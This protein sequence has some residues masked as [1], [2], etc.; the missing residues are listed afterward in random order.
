MSG[1]HRLSCPGIVLRVGL[2]I[3]SSVATGCA[4][5]TSEPAGISVTTERP[6]G[7]GIVIGVV[8][9]QWLLKESKLGRQ[10]NDTLNQFMKD[11]QTL[12]ELEQQELRNLENELLRQGSVLSPSAKQQKEEQLRQRMLDYQQKAGNMSREFQTKQAE[13]LD[14]FREQVDMVVEQIAQERGL[15]L[16][17]EK[18]KNTS[19]RYYDKSMDF[20]STVLEILDRTPLR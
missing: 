18:G 14:E 12:L 17:V 10:V 7:S 15:R 6:A 20:S 13:L 19:T 1:S 5:S 3:L 2:S 8:D 11:R 4:A 16:V 9:T